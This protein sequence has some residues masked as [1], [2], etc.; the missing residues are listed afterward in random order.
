MAEVDAV[1]M[2]TLVEQVGAPDDFL[3]VADP[4][5]PSPFAN[6][7]GKCVEHGDNAMWRAALLEGTEGFEIPF[8]GLF[9]SLDMRR[10]ADMAC[11][12]LAAAAD[13]AAK[14][15]HRQGCEADAV[16]AQANHLDHIAPALHAAID[17]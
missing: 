9:L 13:R 10:D 3:Q 4:H 15:Y 5:Q 7:I 8:L 2:G 12:V 1:M 16:G 6:V 17:P 11:A 14:R